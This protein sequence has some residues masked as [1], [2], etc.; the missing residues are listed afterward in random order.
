MAVT[1]RLT[2]LICLLQY[3]RVGFEEYRDFLPAGQAA[4]P[5]FTRATRIMQ[6]PD[7]KKRQL[8]AEAA[9]RL[10]ATRPFHK[11]KLDDV[12]AEAGVGKG[13][14]YVYFKS[15]EDLYFWLIYDAFSQVIEQLESQ[16]GQGGHSASQTLRR[17]IAE[18]VKFSF[19][20]PQLF[21]LMRS[22]GPRI[23]DDRWE[24]K[25][26]ELVTLIER[27]IRRG[28]KSG[29]FDDPHPEVTALC[30]PGLMRSVMLFGTRGLDRTT[31]T[32]QLTRLVERGV[33]GGGVCSG[34]G[35]DKQTGKRNV[36][37]ATG[38]NGR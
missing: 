15:K 7:E 23:K 30:L 16:L 18:L 5:Q 9:A 25:R 17:I 36:A 2:V 35:N 19:D 24:D 34:D 33:C 6:R 28:N 38:R 3:W 10:F 32:A 27:T 26:K 11:V 13:T 31:V 37:V 21:E 4:P 29:E 20:N 1:A 12:A 8:I 14:L 22:A